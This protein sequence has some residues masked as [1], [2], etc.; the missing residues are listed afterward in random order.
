MVSYAALMRNGEVN[1]TFILC[2]RVVEEH[3]ATPAGSCLDYTYIHMLLKLFSEAG[4]TKAISNFIKGLVVY[5]PE[6]YPRTDR[7]QLAVA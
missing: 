5:S 6:N 3:I 1:V 2:F 4:D 7:H